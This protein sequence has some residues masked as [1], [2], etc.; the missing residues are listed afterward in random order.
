M[1]SNRIYIISLLVIVLF[2]PSVR[3]SQVCTETVT[4]VSECP[5]NVK[6][7]EK[8][9]TEKCN[10][11]CGNS[12]R[13]IK[14]KYHCMLDS[15]HKYLIEMCAIPEYVFDYCPAYD[16]KGPQIQK[17]ESRRCNTSSSRTYYNSDELFFCD[18]TNC[19]DSL[20]STTSDSPSETTD[21]TMKQIPDGESWHHHL[22]WILA[23]ITVISLII[24][25]IFFIRKRQQS[26]ESSD[27]HQNPTQEEN[28]GSN[29]PLLA[30]DV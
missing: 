25:L 24:C 4:N 26:S 7:Y 18:L 11:A 1:N 30:N 2:S 27:C 13:D 28:G 15:T 5:S 19:L 22:I 16:L 3:T 20:T 9:A 29:G 17:D 23:A 8:R 21:M 10:K 14:Y 12:K 6:E